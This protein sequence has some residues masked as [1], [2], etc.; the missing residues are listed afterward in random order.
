VSEETKPTLPASTSSGLIGPPPEPIVRTIESE[1][2]QFI[3]SVDALIESLPLVMAMVRAARQDASTH[4]DEV[5]REFALAVE[6]DGTT[7]TVTLKPEGVVPYQ[8]WKRRAERTAVAEG[9]LPRGFVVSLVSQ[10]DAFLGGLIRA[11]FALKPG[12]LNSSERKLAYSDLVNFS[13]IDDARE[14]VVEKEV[15][16]VLRESHVKQIEWLEKRFDIKLREGLPIWPEF[17]EVTERRNLF[18]HTSGIVSRQYLD[19]CREH[20]VK[21]AARVKPAVRL[22]ANR[23]Y[24]QTAHAIVL[25]MGIKLGHVF[26]RK[27]A[28]D[29]REQA[30]KHLNNVGFDLLVEGRY[31]LAANVFDFATET[32]KKHADAESRLTFV[33][34][35]AQAYKWMG[36]EEK[37]RQIVNAEDWSAVSDLFKLAARVLKDEFDFAIGLVRSI[38]KAGELNAISY[39]TWPLFRKLR[40]V[41]EFVATFEEVF[42][43]PL[44]KVTQETAVTKVSEVPE[45]IGASPQTTH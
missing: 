9:L 11:L 26:W 3:G 13:S 10:Y 29:Q 31:Q 35:R 32:L 43:E 28:P 19:V 6:D 36:N 27:L 41:P 2:D 8:R 12:A 15:E 22:A 21:L 44:S 16:S 34:N 7:R 1:L 24:L 17:V 20:G 14:Y 45:S 5:E 4:L 40:D 39:R 33:V 37:A 18:V 42:G 23:K 38:G 30:D 25:E